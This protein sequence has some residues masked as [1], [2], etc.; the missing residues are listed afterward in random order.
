MRAQVAG[1]RMPSAMLAASDV[2]S[3]PFPSESFDLVLMLEVFEHVGN[4]GVALEE[5]T[6][7]SRKY[8][9]ASVPNEPWWR[10]GN[11]LRFKY[12]RDFGNTPEHIHH[13]SSRRFMHFI[14]GSFKV[15]ELRQPFLWTFILAEKL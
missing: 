4:P 2:H 5:V 9:L 3:M 1:S 11:M 10:L 12:L 7:V 15:L 6:R 8:L 14:S 13:W